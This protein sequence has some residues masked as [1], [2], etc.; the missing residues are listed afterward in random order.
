MQ[1]C[2]YFVLSVV[3]FHDLMISSIFSSSD[4]A[5]PSSTKFKLSPASVNTHVV[6]LT[7][8]TATRFT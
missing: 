4:V 1:E 3:P 8:V 5:I 7:H 2:S 6:L